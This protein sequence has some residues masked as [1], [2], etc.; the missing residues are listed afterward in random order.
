MVRGTC[1]AL[2][3]LLMSLCQAMAAAQSPLPVVRAV[4]VDAAPRRGLEWSTTLQLGR[5]V[6]FRPEYEMNDLD[7]AE[8]VFRTHLLGIRSDVTRRYRDH[9]EKQSNGEYTKK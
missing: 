1:F 4:R 6:R 3:C 9:T 2:A 7:L 8:G 5:H